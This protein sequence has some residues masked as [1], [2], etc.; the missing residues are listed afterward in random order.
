MHPHIL[1]IY[2]KT[3]EDNPSPEPSDRPLLCSEIYDTVTGRRFDLEIYI[4]NVR[5]DVKHVYFIDVFYLVTVGYNTDAYALEFG[6]VIQFF[7]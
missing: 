7:V 5:H 4:R 2:S 6:V 3:D 1:R